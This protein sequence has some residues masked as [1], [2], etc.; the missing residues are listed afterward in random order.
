MLKIQRNSFGK[1][2][3]TA[4]LIL[5]RLVFYSLFLFAIFATIFL[6][7]FSGN[8]KD[9]PPQNINYIEDAIESSG[10]NIQ[11][12]I[13]KAKAHF[14]GFDKGFTLRLEN[15]YINIGSD[16]VISAPEMRVRLKLS[17]LLKAKIRFR[18]IE[19]TK[20]QLL[21]KASQGEKFFDAASKDSFISIYRNSIY[22]LFDVV[23]KDNNIIPVEK[24]NLKDA[25]FSFNRNGKYQNWKLSKANL[26]FYNLQNSTYLR[27]EI[28]TTIRGLESTITAD[29]R[30]LKNDRL[31]IDLTYKNFPSSALG[32]VISELDWLYKLNPILNGS[33]E[34]ML[35]KEGISSTTLL[36]TALNFEQEG[37]NKSKINFTGELDLIPGAEGIIKPRIKGK[38]RVENLEMEYL[39]Q[40]WPEK[41]GTDIRMEMLKNYS[42]GFF[43]SVGVSFLYRFENTDFEK[44]IEESFAAEGDLKKANIIF[45]P[46]YPTLEKVDGIFN[47]TGEN[48]FIQVSKARIG[49]F[50]FNDTDIRI[51]GV[52]RPNAVIEIDG[53]GKGDIVELRPLVSAIN[54]ERDKGFFYNT[55]DIS[56][57]ADVKFYYRDNINHGFDKSVLKL[58]L[59]AKL[60]KISVKN[61]LT[62]INYTADTGEMTLNNDGMN[63]ESSGLMNGDTAKVKV[64][65]GFHVKNDISINL[66]ADLSDSNIELIIKDYKKY[67]TGKA[68][69]EAE[70]RS[71]EEDNYFAVN[72]DFLKTSIN[73]PYLS[74][75]KKENEVT[76]ASFNGRFIKDKA[77]EISSLRI[78]T[79]EGVSEG[80]ALIARERGAIAD[81]F[82]F[83]KLISGKNNA[84]VYLVR[85]SQKTSG[86]KFNDQYKIKISGRSFDLGSFISHYSTLIGEDSSAITAEINV[87]RLHLANDVSLE[88]TQGYLNCTSAEC[89]RASL[90]GKISD[91]G[92]EINLTYY[93]ENKDNPYGIKD[94][95]LYTNN[96]GKMMEGLAFS[97]AIEGGT[98]SIEAK[99]YPETDTGTAGKIKMTGYRI[100]KAPVLTRIFSLASLT[101]IT[102]LL[103]GSGVPMKQLEGDFSI[104]HEYLS[105]RNIITHGNSL[106]ITARGTINLKTSEMDLTGYVTPSYSVNSLFNKIPILNFIT[107][108]K[109]EGLIAT[110]YSVNGKYPDAD[111]S[112]NPLSALTPGFLREIWGKAETNIDIKSKED[113]DNSERKNFK[114]RIRPFAD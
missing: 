107:G 19:L 54:H 23:S 110:K 15:S 92:G 18:E 40:L 8:E 32:E 70:Y 52:N 67:F 44:V 53:K 95:K 33:A 100:L 14:E 83:S 39:Q 91:N 102:E 26:N 80:K 27:T 77:I 114:S 99:S 12:Y 37:L 85:Q 20:P 76:D 30:V 1:N 113:N 11:A 48:V 88:N 34:V 108:K 68:T 63:L 96:V 74:I 58:D 29:A 55:R 31:K 59:T 72:A 6:F 104:K 82:Y 13:G 87:D 4:F 9:I 101:G 84:T 47:L 22:N 24:I 42:K 78:I 43:K 73:F 89:L 5:A 10:K 38:T 86:N 94:F 69:I 2:L 106:G 60:K 35:E 105:L 71:Q 3:K 98:A 36:N 112:V 51:I 21:F 62:G 66:N 81:E 111:V 28:T 7:M 50:K 16:L 65:A 103:S 49:K 41:Y 97:S 57:D 90:T 79:A 61:V 56:A 109:G 64:W 25:I 93:P 46:R 17:D 75:E 45:N